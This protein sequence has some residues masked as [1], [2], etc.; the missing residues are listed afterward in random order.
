M[1]TVAWLMCHFVIL[2]Y[3]PETGLTLHNTQSFVLFHV[4]FSPMFLTTSRVLEEPPF[5]FNSCTLHNSVLAFVDDR[6]G[7]KVSLN[8]QFQWLW[9]YLWLSTE[10]SLDY[11]SAS[12]QVFHEHFPR[13]WPGCLS[14]SKATQL[15]SLNVLA[16]I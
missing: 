5:F 1:K 2:L 3:S 12:L 13:W 8:H 14:F 11:P 7:R 16:F 10:Y 15:A 4:L 9:S 6:V